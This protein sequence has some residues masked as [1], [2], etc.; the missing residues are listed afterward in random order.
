MK[1][2]EEVKAEIEEA[3]KCMR[4]Y[5]NLRNKELVVLDGETKYLTGDELDKYCESITPVALTRPAL[6]KELLPEL[7]KMFGVEYARY[8]EELGGEK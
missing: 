3:R 2:L 6:L 7:E 5:K 8:E 4:W 1:E